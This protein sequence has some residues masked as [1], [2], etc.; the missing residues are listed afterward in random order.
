VDDAQAV[1]ALGK[2]DEADGG[3]RRVLRRPGRWVTARRLERYLRRRERSPARER[4]DR[5]LAL[6]A[7]L[8]L[9]DEARLEL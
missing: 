2:L 1:G 9:D 3:A 7:R 6:P 5:E 4:L 8:A